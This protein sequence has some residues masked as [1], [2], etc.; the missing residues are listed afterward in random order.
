[1]LT[2]AQV[3]VTTPVGDSFNVVGTVPDSLWKLA[4]F[5]KYVVKHAILA[6]CFKGCKQFCKWL[7]VY[8]SM[9]FNDKYL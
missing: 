5:S 3:V 9:L 7:F 1:M 4:V 8:H 6:V 2:H